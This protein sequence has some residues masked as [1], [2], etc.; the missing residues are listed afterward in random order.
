MDFLR[1]VFILNLKWIND[2]LFVRSCINIIGF[3]KNRGE[4]IYCIYY[5]FV[6][7][8]R[9]KVGCNLLL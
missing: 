8:F 9:I 1:Y 4:N 7:I 6:Y 2:Y 3:F 5:V